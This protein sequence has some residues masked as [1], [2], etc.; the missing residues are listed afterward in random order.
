[1]C[2]GGI[3]KINDEAKSNRVHHPDDDPKLSRNFVRVSRQ[4]LNDSK[5]PPSPAR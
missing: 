2:K 5:F 3:K 4:V 1:M